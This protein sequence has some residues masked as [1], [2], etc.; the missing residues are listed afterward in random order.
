[1][2]N[3]IANLESVVSPAALAAGAPKE[4][5]VGKINGGKV[6]FDLYSEIDDKANTAVKTIIAMA[7][8][9]TCA[10]FREF[11][12]SAQEMAT[13]QDAA[14]GFKAKDGAK[15]AELYGPKRRNINTR[16]SEAKQ[17]F[18]VA[19]L[20]PAVVAEKG[21]F[22]AVIASRDWLGDKGMK[23][24]GAHA[25]TTEQRKAKKI[26][27]QNDEAVEAAKKV[28]PQ[29]QGE[30]IASWMARVAAKAEAIKQSLATT[31]LLNQIKNLEEV[32]SEEDVMLAVFDYIRSKGPDA[33]EACAKQLEEQAAEDRA[34]MDK[35]A[36]EAPM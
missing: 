6:L 32:A 28:L 21:Y 33:M 8:E 17:I 7:A 10:E 20:A 9:Y 23:W 15:G 31:A 19:K 26:Q 16:M 25:L 30:S 36:V 1:M 14:Q 3:V 24:D 34:E 11:V 22:S 12:S 13:A 29:A 4:L 2:E 18:G 5:K 35:K 27:K